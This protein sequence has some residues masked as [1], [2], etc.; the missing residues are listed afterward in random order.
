MDNRQTR[1]GNV[2]FH[3]NLPCVKAVWPSFSPE[4]LHIPPNVIVQLLHAYT[5][6]IRRQMPGR[7]S[8]LCVIVLMQYVKKEK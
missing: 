7:L 3:C 1:F 4:M 8:F 2:Y 6:L 5:E